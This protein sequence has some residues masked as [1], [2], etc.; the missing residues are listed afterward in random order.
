VEDPEQVVLESDPPHR[1]AYTSRTVTRE[2][3]DAVGLDEGSFARLEKD[4]RSKV[5]FQ[6]EDHTEPVKLTV[7]TRSVRCE[8]RHVGK[9]YR[10]VADRV[11]EFEVAAGDRPSPGSTPSAEVRDFAGVPR[12]RDK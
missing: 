8:Q 5:T 6:I 2:V 1:L 3:A 7:Y 10:W 11:F 12:K 4:R 9:H